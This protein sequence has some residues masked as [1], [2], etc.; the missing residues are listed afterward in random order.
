MVMTLCV[1]VCVAVLLKQADL[2]AIDGATVLDAPQATYALEV[3]QLSEP[4]SSDSG[5]HLILRT[6]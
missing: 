1:D 2:N 5:V 4:V 6:E 3:G